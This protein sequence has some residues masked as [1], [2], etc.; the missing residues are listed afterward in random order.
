MEKGVK[1]E[2]KEKT[3]VFLSVMIMCM[4]ILGICMLRNREQPKKY[5]VR[6]EKGIEVASV[7][8]NSIKGAREIAGLKTEYRFFGLYGK[9]RNFV[10]LDF[11][12]VGSA[13]VDSTETS[14][15]DDFKMNGYP[16]FDGNTLYAEEG[17]YFFSDELGFKLFKDSFKL[18]DYD[19][20]IDYE[21]GK[22]YVISIG[23]ELIWLQFNPEWVSAFGT[24]AN[25][26]GYD[27][28]KEV[29]PNT[30]YVYSIHY[31]VE[32]YGGLGVMTME[33]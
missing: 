6:K 22:C 11:E 23:R 17:Y 3:K 15:F 30:V 16:R 33:F 8:G 12:Y 26:V 21:K 27:W 18:Y 10:D 2:R 32:R 4:I 20:S 7:I 1:E 25:R 19:F 28:N 24:V 13:K 14:T 31:D 9:E 5:L 29:V